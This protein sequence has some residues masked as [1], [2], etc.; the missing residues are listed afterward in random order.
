VVAGQ[1]DVERAAAFIPEAWAR[2]VA[3][4]GG[5]VH[6]VDG[7][8]VCLTGVP[9]PQFNPTL[10]ANLP[11]DAAEALTA[12][13]RAYEGTG[14]HMGIDLEVSLHAPVR[15][16]AERAG[17]TMIEARPGM[18]M[19]IGDADFVDPPAG[20]E[21][22]RVDDPAVLDR[23]AEV[24][25]IAFGG[26]PA[27]GFLPDAML[28][29]PAQGVY[30]ARVD[31]AIVGSGECIVVDGVMGVFGIATLPEYR[32]RG[33]AAALTSRMIRDRA[34]EIDLAC[35]DASELGQRVYERLGFLANSTWEVWVRRRAEL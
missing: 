14:L 7:L 29:D 17:L 23:I 32:R 16:A 6:D 8:R 35:L 24:D 9:M 31:G 10:V 5:V 3:T 13:E 19:R 34:H 11:T 18:T 33:I 27:R 26:E 28:D 25:A 21:I 4:C 20:V 22:V 1:H 30:A 2:R 12:A 15:A